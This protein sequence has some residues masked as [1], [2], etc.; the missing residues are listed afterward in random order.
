MLL[1]FLCLLG[2]QAVAGGGLSA[3]PSSSSYSSESDGSSGA[4]VIDMDDDDLL[5]DAPFDGYGSIVLTLAVPLMDHDGAQQGD[6][7]VF[8]KLMNREWTPLSAGFF[9]LVALTFL[10]CLCRC[11]GG[12]RTRQKASA[13]A[14]PPLLSKSLGSASIS[15]EDRTSVLMDKATP[16]YATSGWRQAG[17]RGWLLPRESS[18][19][20]PQL[21]DGAPGLTG[22]V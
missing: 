18:V 13:A 6:E 14:V 9:A 5:W 19:G 20:T 8:A 2:Q 10:L 11:R 17:G 16:T 12:R 1:P 7:N 21:G 3:F 15:D 4:L 22:Q